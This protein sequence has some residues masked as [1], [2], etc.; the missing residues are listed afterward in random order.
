M[1]TNYLGKSR[2]T[3][4]LFN[5]L[6]NT[7]REKLALLKQELSRTNEYHED[8]LFYK[9]YRGIE[10][11]ETSVSI[12]DTTYK[13]KMSS[14]NTKTKIVDLAE[15]RIRDDGQNEIPKRIYSGKVWY[16]EDFRLIMEKSD[17]CLQCNGIE[18]KG[19]DK[20]AT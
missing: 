2:L 10:T 7:S 4:I 3:K 5:Y 20:N 12:D 16:D 19:V 9:K 13:F 15:I 1:A 6:E 18:K 11:L 8:V 17:C 14:F